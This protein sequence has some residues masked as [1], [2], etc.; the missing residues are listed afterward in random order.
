M[1]L[2]RRSSLRHLSV[3]YDQ[4]ETR[5]EDM[6]STA[7]LW[8]IYGRNL[9]RYSRKFIPENFPTHD[10]IMFY[11]NNCRNRADFWPGVFIRLLSCVVRK[12]W[13]LQKRVLSSLTLPQSLDIETFATAQRVVNSARLGGRLVPVAAKLVNGPWCKKSRWAP[14]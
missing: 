13:Y 12:I 8:G 3:V 5:I 14:Y 11:R 6:Q 1:A 2:F 10:H 4:Y 7:G 9:R